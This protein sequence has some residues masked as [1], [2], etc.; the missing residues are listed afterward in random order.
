MRSPPPFPSPRLVPACADACCRAIRLACR[1]TAR[2]S[3]LHGF[4]SSMDEAAQF[5]VGSILFLHFV[6]PALI[7]MNSFLVVAGYMAKKH[8]EDIRFETT[9][10]MV[11]VAKLLQA[12]ANGSTKF[13]N[14]SMEP[15][16]CFLTEEKAT[17]RRFCCEVVVRVLPYLLR[18]T[19]HLLC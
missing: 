14:P 15:Y 6:C 9:R 19:A 11:M 1:E 18:C 5:S 10:A 17:F 13:D 16:N 7:S 3:V 4:S 2:L 8:M 12:L